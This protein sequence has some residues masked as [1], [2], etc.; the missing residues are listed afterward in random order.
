M[1]KLKYFVIFIGLTSG[2][3]NVSEKNLLFPLKMVII[4]KSLPLRSE[5]SHKTNESSTS[6]LTMHRMRSG[7]QHQQQQQLQLLLS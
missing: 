1:V 3:K 5:F 7:L 6:A 2:P 4:N